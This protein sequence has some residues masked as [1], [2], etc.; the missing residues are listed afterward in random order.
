M[1][2]AGE[3]I[4]G[5]CTLQLEALL[6][7]Q[8]NIPGQGG[9][10]AGDVDQSSGGEAGDGFDGIGVQAL[11]GRVHHHHIGLDALFFQLQGGGT[12]VGA[13]KFGVFDAVSLGVVLGILHGQGD[14]L[15][16]DE[17]ARSAGH[18]QGNG[19]HTTV[20]VENGVLFGDPGGFDGGG[21]ELLG[22][23]VVDLVEGS[24]AETEGKAAE[25]VLDP[26]VA[27]EG[28]EFIAQDGVAGAGVDGE[29]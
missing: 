7:Q 16:A 6:L 11:A 25:G 14:D 20:E 21:V 17:L 28:D 29:D 24:G 4:K 26:A 10:V 12:G 1:G 5:L 8:G 2:A 15:H 27:V 22:L 18:G 19:A 9:G 23:V 13:E 3:Q